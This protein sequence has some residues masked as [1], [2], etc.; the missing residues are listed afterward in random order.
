M[1]YTKGDEDTSKIKEATKGKI[2]IATNL[3]GRGT[4]IDASSIEEAGGLHVIFSFLPGNRRIQDQ[5]FGRT[6]RKGLSGTARLIIKQEEIKEHHLQKEETPVFDICNNIS[7][8][9]L[10]C[11]KI[12]YEDNL[13][14]VESDSLS[15]SARELRIKRGGNSPETKIVRLFHL[16]RQRTSESD[17]KRQQTYDS[18]MDGRNS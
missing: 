14:E 18:I 7:N 10:K 17:R 11:F 3:S 8:S 13:W 15:S 4:D 1:T 2:I 5:G 6:A 16:K 12:S 9:I